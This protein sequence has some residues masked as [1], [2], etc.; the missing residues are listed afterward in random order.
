MSNDITWHLE[1][2]RIATLKYNPK[3]PRIIKKS[4]AE[5][6]TD[7]IKKFGMIDKPILNSDY[8]VIGGHQRVKILKRMGIS[9]CECW[10]CDRLLSDEE[11]DHL[12]IGLNLNQGEWDFDMLS[13]QYEMEKI[14]AYGFDE[15][16]LQEISKIAA[17]AG[18]IIDEVKEPEVEEEVEI[19]PPESE[20]ITKLGDIYILGPHRLVCGDSTDL[21]VAKT[22]LGG[23]IPVMMVTDPPYGVDYKPEWRFNIKKKHKDPARL[24]S[25]E[26][27]H[28]SDWKLA[29]Q[30]CP[31][32]VVYVWHA[33]RYC[34]EV[35]KNLEECG[36]EI[37]SQI[38]WNK[39]HFAIGRGNYHWKHEASWYAVRKGKNHSWVGDKTQSTV[40]DI[41]VIN[42][43]RKHEQA[44]NEK[45]DHSTQKPLECMLRPL[46]NHMKRGSDEW[47]YDPFLGSGTTLMAAEKH[48]VRCCGVE[49]SPIYCDVIVRRWIEK[50]KGLGLS[51]NVIR[52][53]E[54]T[55]DFLG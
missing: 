5:K 16:Q 39:N 10:V 43:L 29:Y 37:V 42:S 45:T 30:H 4:Q 44:D 35:K 32:N 52:N 22:A 26:N 15:T 49:I 9:I 28:E 23:C 54:E 50:R 48:K 33:A 8:M 34:D 25:V 2:V 38:I 18:A 24:G 11:I 1:S 41:S 13:S 7:L 14:L 27:D 17:E 53:G 3:N 47:V 46:R 31:G 6:L 55:F 51:V 40:W 21:S 12:C 36:F 20:P 19:L